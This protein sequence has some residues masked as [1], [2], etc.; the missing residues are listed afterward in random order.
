MKLPGSM[1]FSPSLS[2]HCVQSSKTKRR[3]KCDSVPSL[4][5]FTIQDVTP[6]SA[7]GAAAG[8]A[9]IGQG[10]LVAVAVDAGA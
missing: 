1:L 5:L 8:V 6:F 2:Q 7:T 9:A 3:L 4:Y 10:D